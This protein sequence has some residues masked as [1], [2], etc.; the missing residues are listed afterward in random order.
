MGN[1]RRETSYNYKK[2]VNWFF[3]IKGEFFNIVA[4]PFYDLGLLIL[5]LNKLLFEGKKILY[6]TYNA[7]YIRYKLMNSKINFKNLIISSPLSFFDGDLKFDLVI[8]DDISGVSII[9]D[10]LLIPF[11]KGINSE[12][13][14]ILSMR[15][16]IK[17]HKIY[18]ISDNV[19]LFTEPRSI[20]TKIDLNYDMPYVVFEFLEWFMINKT[21]VVLITKD[22]K[23]SRN[24]Y[25]YMK[26]YSSFHFNN[27]FIQDDFKSFSE[28]ENFEKDSYIY[29]TSIDFLNEFQKF[30]F[31][32]SPKISDLNI[33]VFFASDS[34][35]NYKNLLT[36]CGVPMFLKNCKNEV[37][38][39]S[40]YENM[41]IFTAK[42]ISRS[43]NKR[44]WEFGLR[45]Y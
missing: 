22:Y 24:V 45:K 7:E 43:Y 32:E 29:I 35:F 31:E 9:E 23:S 33:V 28:F 4:H 36:L 38:F 27:L 25:G 40:N 10:S 26:R 8:F 19:G 14:I 18:E 1:F 44:L 12:K 3:D 21:K 17:D 15:E 20:K 16:M 2:L 37:I 5:F 6:I 13:K 34:V 41:E 39:V 42:S 30:I 11:L